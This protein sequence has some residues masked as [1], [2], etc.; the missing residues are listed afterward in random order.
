MHSPSQRTLNLPFV[1][2]YS[3]KAVLAVII[4][5]GTIS[6]LTIS[7]TG[8]MAQRKGSQ[9]LRSDVKTINTAIGVYRAKGGDLSGFTDP[10]HV[11]LKLKSQIEIAEGVPYPVASSSVIDPRVR[12]GYLSL[13]D[14]DSDKIRAFWDASLQRFVLAK[15]GASGIKRFYL[16]GEK[17][18][19]NGSLATIATV[20]LPVGNASLTSHSAKPVKKDGQED[21]KAETLTS[22]AAEGSSE[23]VSLRSTVVQRAMGDI[24]TKH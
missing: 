13:D 19:S 21:K 12:I 20:N 14:S 17:S 22:D 6:S 7:V 18:S 16:D 24:S 11:I 15:T 8:S 5:V 9:K 23:S 1:N 4:L 2:G 10:E 3:I